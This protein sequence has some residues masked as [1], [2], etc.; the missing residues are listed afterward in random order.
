M[1]NL[2][3][4]NC[5]SHFNDRKTK[6]KCDDCK[7]VRLIDLI[8]K[9]KK[10]LVCEMYAMGKPMVEIQSKLGLSYGCVSKIID[11][12]LGIGEQPILVTIDTY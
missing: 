12:Y 10:G 9:Q 2:V 3:C 4:R 11:A 1:E 5:G 6:R 8:P 7:G